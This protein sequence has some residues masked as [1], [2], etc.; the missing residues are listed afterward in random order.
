MEEEEDDTKTERAVETVGVSSSLNSRL[1][2]VI[3]G[4]VINVRP[5]PHLSGH[6]LIRNFISAD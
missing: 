3:I 6:C 4:Q 2:N 5:R 1:L